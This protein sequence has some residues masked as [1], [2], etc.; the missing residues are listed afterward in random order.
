MKNVPVEL[1]IVEIGTGAVFVLLSLMLGDG[2]FSIGNLFFN[3]LKWNDTRGSRKSSGNLSEMM[4]V[5]DCPDW[6][7]NGIVISFNGEC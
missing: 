4:I 2:D 7:R 1:T 5:G 6:C 3:V